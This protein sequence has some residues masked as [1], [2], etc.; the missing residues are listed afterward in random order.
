MRHQQCQWMFSDFSFETTFVNYILNTHGP[1][2]LSRHSNW[3]TAGRSGNR[4][5]VGARF[6]EQVQTCPG[7]H[8][9]CCTMG[10]RSVREKSGRGVVL[11]THP[12]RLPTSINSS[13][14]PLPV[15]ACGSVT[16]SLSHSPTHSI[17]LTHSLIHNLTHS[18][19]AP[20]LSQLHPVPTTPSFFQKI[21]LIII[22]PSTS[23][24]LPMA[25]FPPTPCAHLSHTRYMLRP[26]PSRFYHPLNVG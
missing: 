19:L 9:A 5:T 21:H 4:I 20:I 22:L 1:L 8:S 15:C 10:T 14:I 18:P 25:S 17:T 11:T 2:Q 12:L 16:Y 24:S 7:V 6:F 26:S 23:Q 3:L 13:A